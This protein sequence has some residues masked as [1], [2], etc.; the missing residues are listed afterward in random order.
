MNPRRLL[1]GLATA[2][3]AFL[4]VG[5]S[6]FAASGPTVVPDSAEAWYASTPVVNCASPVGCPPVAP[7]AT[8]SYPANTLHVG[9]SN[10]QE[11]ARSYVQPDLSGIPISQMAISG[12][13]SLPLATIAGSGNSNTSSASLEACLATAAFPDGVQGSTGA[14]PKIDCSVH[15]KVKVG[16]KAFTLDL[17]PFLAAWNAGLPEYGIALIPDLTGAS[18]LTSW[19]VAF[20]GRKLKGATHISSALTLTSAGSSGTTPG[21]TFTGSSGTGPSASAGSGLSL[22]SGSTGSSAATGLPAS[23]SLNLG[24]LPNSAAGALP[25]T[26]GQAPVLAGP[27]SARPTIQ[28]GGPQLIRN[29]GFQYPEAMLLPLAFLVGLVLVVKLLTGDATPSRRLSR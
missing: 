25:T 24:T 16:K 4:A 13:M 11:T 26:S 1:T 29:A 15:A 7:P 3:F 9:V 14:E 20:N 2:G 6:A 19:Q 18:P 28:A 10:G 5:G 17:T 21:G 22:P 23:S 27:A 12:T 8:N